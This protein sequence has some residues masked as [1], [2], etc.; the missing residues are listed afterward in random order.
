[1][2]AVVFTAGG[3]SDGGEVLQ[4]AESRDALAEPSGAQLS[5]PAWKQLQLL[6]FDL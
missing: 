3:P 6:L 1:M 5:L 2:D 4:S